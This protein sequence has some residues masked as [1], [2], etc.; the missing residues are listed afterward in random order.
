V[1]RIAPQSPAEA[2][3]AVLAGNLTGAIVGPVIVGFLAERGAYEQA[4]L[5]AGA[6]LL[7]GAAGALVSK[8]LSGAPA[9]GSTAA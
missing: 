5:L 6:L 7:V 4:W 2:S 9:T 1:V 8:R 3:G